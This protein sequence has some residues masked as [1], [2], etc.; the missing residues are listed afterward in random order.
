MQNYLHDYV[1]K[2]ER[3]VKIKAKYLFKNRDFRNERRMAKMFIIF[4]ELLSGESLQQN[5]VSKWGASILHICDEISAPL[6]MLTVHENINSV[7][8]ILTNLKC[9]Y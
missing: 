6:K 9:Y 5:L 1:R 8:K 4:L 3:E 7:R 2:W